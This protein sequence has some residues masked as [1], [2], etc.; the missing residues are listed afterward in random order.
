MDGL[1]DSEAEADELQA[2][3]QKYLDL[4]VNYQMKADFI[5]KIGISGGVKKEKTNYYPENRRRKVPTIEKARKVKANE[6]KR[7]QKVS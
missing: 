5:C 6:K 2:R 4:T 1:S 7:K 3:H